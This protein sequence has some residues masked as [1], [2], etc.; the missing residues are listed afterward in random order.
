[1]RAADARL[2]TVAAVA[3]LGLALTPAPASADT[4]REHQWY[5]EPLKV[6][7]AHQVT[8]GA[9]VTVAV[10]DSGVD[11][12]VPDLAGQVLPG[13]GFA[14]ARGTDGRR[15]FDSSDGHGTSMAGLIAGRGEGPTSVLGIAPRA[16]IL[17]VS[18]GS[19]NGDADIAAG[20]RWSADHGA[21]VVNVSI[22]GGRVPPPGLTDAVAY[23]LQRDVVV[24][25]GA[26]NLDV[27]GRAVGSPASIPGVIAVSGV[28]REARAWAGSSQGPEVALAA[29]AV[30]VP[31]PSPRGVSS[32]G[33]SI[34]DGTSNAAAIVSGAAALVRA[35]YPDMDAANV[36]NRLIATAR[37]QG[38]PGRDTA[39]GFGTVR[40]YEALTADL[41]SV[42]RNP[43]LPPDGNGSVTGSE[44]VGAPG[45]ADGGGIG[46]ALVWAAVFL[47]GLLVVGVVV[48]LLML[49][50]RRPVPAGP[51]PH[52]PP[53]APPYPP[54]PEAHG[55]AP[56]AP[57]PAGTP[58]R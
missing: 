47:L 56:R 13:T 28:D 53:A 15:D 12:T 39:F 49:S 50:R 38:P 5:L 30:R 51:P 25:A 26:G 57:P 42:S 24:V 35:R 29:P 31:A 34:S 6:S 43:L 45:A 9:G 55:P 21:Q 37:D 58:P 19:E 7:Q 54:G 52:R 33:F 10:V 32:T 14:E 23:A 27:T 46:A 17:P 18:L 8:R 41:P 44:P 22:A 36:I 16:K 11:A 48:L 2:V 40:P 1:V 20:I 4:V 3:V